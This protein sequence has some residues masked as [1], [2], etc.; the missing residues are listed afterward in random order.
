MTAPRSLEGKAASDLLVFM[1][2]H[3]LAV[4]ASVSPSGYRR[5]LW[6]DWS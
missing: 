1:N 2:S 5:S 4:Q 3:T 6:L